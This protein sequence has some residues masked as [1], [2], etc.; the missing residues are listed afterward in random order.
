MRLLTAMS[1]GLLG[2]HAE[3]AASDD[4]IP[5]IDASAS[6]GACAAQV[7]HETPLEASAHVPQNTEVAWRSNPPSSGAH[8][9]TFESWAIAYPIVVPRGNY[10]HNE[11]HGG[12]VLLYN[13]DDDCTELADSLAT[14]GH[15][16]PQD[17]LCAPPVNARWIASKDPL[18]PPG[19]AV[20]AAAWGWTYK[21][22]CLDP[23]TLGAFIS[24]RYAQGGSDRENCKDEADPPTP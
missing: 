4:A 18:L 19:V 13:C 6:G 9:P 21:A 2:C 23:E 5:A 7:T 24:F 8:Y 17:P 10:L 16:L 3:P 15:A 20:A 22:S 11:E 12:V 14:I 1:V